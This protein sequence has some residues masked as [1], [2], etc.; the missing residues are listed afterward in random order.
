[1][2]RQL[3]WTMTNDQ[4]PFTRRH[5]ADVMQQ[6]ENLNMNMSSFEYLQS[7]CLIWTLWSAIKIWSSLVD[8]IKCI[9]YDNTQV[10]TFRN[11]M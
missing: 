9:F 7:Q 8:A 10:K 2:T 3:Q 11:K 1:M 5:E 4:G 6:N